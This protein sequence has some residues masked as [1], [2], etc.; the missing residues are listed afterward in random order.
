M[1]D[2]SISNMAK[3]IQK[4]FE[5]FGK[6]TNETVTEAI[7]ATAEDLV[8]ELKRTSPKSHGKRRS[9]KYSRGWKT[10]D[11]SVKK[12]GAVKGKIVYNKEYQ[13]THLLENGHRT[14]SGGTVPGRPHIRP[15][16]AKAEKELITKIK[17]GIKRQ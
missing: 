1:K 13:L 14:R 2:V 9:G 6:A 8:K 12:A 11:T 17:E 4:T 15:A 7:E 5:E 16:Q 10:K 3:E